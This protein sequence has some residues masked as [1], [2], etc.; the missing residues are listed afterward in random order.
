V[1]KL[2]ISQAKESRGHHQVAGET[3][4]K[5]KSATV[6]TIH[7]GEGG[8]LMKERES[9]RAV[10]RSASGLR[11][12]GCLANVDPPRRRWT[13]TLFLLV[14]LGGSPASARDLGV[15]TRILYAADFA[16]QLAILCAVV[17][18]VFPDKSGGSSGNISEYAQHIK[19]EVISQMNG[20]ETIIVLTGAGDAAKTDAAK[21]LRGFRR[22]SEI[23]TSQ[24]R[25]WCDSA[26]ATFVRQVIST[27][28]NHHDE[29]DS[30]MVNAKR[31]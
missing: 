24:L 10:G 18:P 25:Q 23:E 2:F 12:R 16:S 31:R 5:F 11:S 4:G 28:D 22:G 29:L 1:E 27:H 8:L 13:W 6:K 15:L 20:A 19:T 3:P 30:L 26:A 14:T 21:I 17:D 7:I 9:M